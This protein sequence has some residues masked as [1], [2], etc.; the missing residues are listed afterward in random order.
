MDSPDKIQSLPLISSNEDLA[1]WRGDFYKD[2]FKRIFDL[3]LCLLFLPFAAPIL[4][5]LMVLIKLD[6]K[7]PAIFK[8]ER[9]GLGGERI[10]IYKLRTMQVNAQEILEKLLSQN[11]ALKEEWDKSH[12]LKKDPR[13]TRMGNFIRVFSLDELPQFFNVLK[14]DMSFVGPRPMLIEERAKYGQN[15]KD[16]QKNKPGITGLWQISGRNDSDYNSRIHFVKE[17]N[18][19]CSFALDS[20]VLLRTLPAVLLKKGAY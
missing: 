16:Y 8:S 10:F 7:G 19:T 14:G 13:I 4:L 2:Y 12:K 3:T 1:L 15:L 5:L 11:S 18:E 6:S 20:K 9:I 17:Y